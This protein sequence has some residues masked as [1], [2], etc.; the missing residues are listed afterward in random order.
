MVKGFV[1]ALR[2][3]TILPVPGKDSDRMVSAL[4]WFPVVGLVLGSLLYGAA[5][6]FSGVAGGTWP[7]ATAVAV[8]ILGIVLTRGLHM[9]GLADWAD[10]F[11][12]GRERDE[13]LRIMKDTQVGTFGVCALACIVLAKW[14]CLTRLI[15]A[16]VPEWVIVA[17]VASRTCQVDMAVA[18]PYARDNG[19]TGAPFVKGAGLLHLSV[20]GAVAFALLLVVPGLDLTSIAAVALGWLVARAFG[21]WCHRRVGGVTGDLLGACSEIVETVVLAFGAIAA[22]LPRLWLMKP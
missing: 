3:L 9:D 7:E 6:L 1:S 22:D 2:T 18:Q 17:Y 10:G 14:V 20:A 5:R 4:P 21:L 16:G 13:V 11:W 19:G 15:V 12:G 8:L